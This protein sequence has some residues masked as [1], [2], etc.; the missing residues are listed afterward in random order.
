MP[1]HVSE[2]LKQASARQA[3]RRLVSRGE[4]PCYRLMAAEDGS[5]TVDGSLG[6]TV[7]AETKRAAL[8]AARTAIAAVSEV[9]PESFDLEV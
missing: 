6:V 3:A 5:W 7:S 4:R 2:A 1:R 9:D 8:T